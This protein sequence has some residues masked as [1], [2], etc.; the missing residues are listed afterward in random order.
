[1]MGN[2]HSHYDNLK[3]A[4]SAPAEVIRAAYKALSQRY[5]PD[6]NGSPD[7]TRVMRILNDAYAV[8]SDPERR[9]AYDLSLDQSDRETSATPQPEDSEPSFNA[10][11]TANPVPP[12]P[13]QDAA[14]NP[15][16]IPMA[17]RWTRF[18]ARSFDISWETLLLAL[19]GQYWLADYSSSYVALVNGPGGTVLASWLFLPIAL[20]LDAIVHQV[21]GNT[22]GKA[23]LGVQVGTLDGRKLVFPE[24]LWRNLSM[25]LQGLALGVPVASLATLSNQSWRLGKGKQA[26]YDENAGFRVRSMRIGFLRKIFFVLAFA[27]LLFV[28]AVIKEQ[29]QEVDR[30]IQSRTASSSYIWTNPLTQAVASVPPEWKSSVENASNGNTAY[31]FSEAS[32]HALIV[33]GR[34]VAKG[35]TIRDYTHAFKQSV[36][37][38]MTFDEGAFSD[39]GH[40]W[41]ADGKMTTQSEMR[42]HI[43]IKGSGSSFWRVIALQDRPYAYTDDMVATL[44]DRLWATAW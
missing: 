20:V 28:G 5:H 26:S 40:S 27:A 39:D 3:V 15:A 12:A 8:L 10:R 11:E 9:L 35:W 7:A 30:T 36:A 22:P 19:I 38:T 18:L 44:R 34:E 6:K 24:Y 17:G 14:V 2:A 33:M 21:I 4:R 32:G 1:M 43:E 37:E 13:S 25:W 41:Q 31:M 16:L 23:I 42:V 29:H